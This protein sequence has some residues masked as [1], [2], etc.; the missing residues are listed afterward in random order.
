MYLDSMLQLAAG[1]NAF[2]AGTDVISTNVY[3]TGAAADSGAG[4]P[5]WL[6]ARMATALVGGT[7]LQVVLQ[8]SA[9]NATFADV[10]GGKAVPLASATANAILAKMRVPVGLRRYLRV[11]FRSVG[12]TTGGTADAYFVKDV[13]ALQYGA[14]GFTVA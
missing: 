5:F 7:S 11:V 10:Q 3:D 14:S 9:D 2:S 6:F 4:E 1:Q 8:D 12:T 13:E